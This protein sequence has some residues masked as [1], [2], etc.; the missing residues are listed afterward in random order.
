MATQTQ[1]PWPLHDRLRRWFGPHLFETVTGLEY[2]YFDR[3]RRRRPLDG[4]SLE[5]IRPHLE[6]L[7]RLQRLDLTTAP[8]TRMIL[9][10]SWDSCSSNR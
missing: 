1:N 5:A 10:S 6:S 7:P 4:P 8:M 3:F 9:A 2:S